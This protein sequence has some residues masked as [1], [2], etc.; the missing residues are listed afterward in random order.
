MEEE[1]KAIVANATTLLGKISRAHANLLKLGTEITIGA[2]DARLQN[3][4]R[5]WSKFDACNDE[6]VDHLTTLAEDPYVETDIP[7]LGEEAYLVNKGLMLELKRTLQKK[8]ATAASATTSTSAPRTTLPRIQLPTFTGKYEDWPAFRDDLFVSLIGQDKATKP[9]EKMH[10]LK[11]CVKGEAELLIRN[12]SATEANYE[13]AWQTLNDYYENKRLLTRAYLANF[14]SLPKM[15][16][17]SASEL[18]NIFHGIK[19][20]VS[21]LESINRAVESTE[22]LFVYHAVDLLDTRSRREWENSI[23]DSSEPPKYSALEQFLE[24]RLHT[25]ESISPS[26]GNGSTNKTAGSNGNPKSTRS[27][28]ARKQESKEGTKGR[29]SV[30]QSDHFVMFCE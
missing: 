20:T 16:G 8:F 10:Y 18:R 14:L 30:C 13:R 23:S 15:K 24:R 19:T 5:L 7:S 6:L 4:E 27:H 11:S 22:D 17:E 3:L 12:L 25:L 26:K 28:H 21:S 1:V 2:I 9:V 29:C